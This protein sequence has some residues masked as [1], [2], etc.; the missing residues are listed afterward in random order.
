MTVRIA[1][2]SDV[3]ITQQPSEIA[4]RDL[5]SKRFVG[6][7]NLRFFGRYAALADAE[8]V[9]A[10]LVDDL[11]ELKPDHVLS[12]G[13]L[14]GLSLPSEFAAARRALAPLLERANVTSIPGNHDVYVRSAA[15]SGLYDEAFG[16]WTRTEV[17]HEEMPADVAHDYPYPL[18]RY[19]END[20]VLC[21][22]RDVRPAPLHDSSGLVPA[23]Q[24]RALDHL[25]GSQ[26]VA[27]RRKILALHYGLCRHDGSP[28]TRLHGLRNAKDVWDI[29]ERHGVTLVVHGHL[30]HRFVHAQG[31]VAPFAIA[32]P[33][34]LAYSRGDRTYHVYH[35]DTDSVRLEVRRFNAEQQRFNE[36]SAAPGSG[37]IWSAAT[38]ADAARAD[39]QP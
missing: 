12:T 8:T 36:W 11:D 3:H 35:F 38:A 2:F 21:C 31:A 19:I 5:L 29:A 13:D 28:D 34:A 6:W 4:W 39:A 10:A 23:A 9:A 15:A 17:S 32:N 20:I 7:A 24:L 16:T 27:P 14:T 26:A 18:L 37:C 25:L 22:L 1:H 30:H 33:G